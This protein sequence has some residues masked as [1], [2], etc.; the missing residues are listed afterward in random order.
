MEIAALVEN[1]GI[2]P[3]S[4]AV[5]TAHR[6]YKL[7][8]QSGFTRGRRVNQVR[9]DM[10]LLTPKPCCGHVPQRLQ[11]LCVQGLH[12]LDMLY[13][14]TQLGPGVCAYLTFSSASGRCYLPVHLLPPRAQTLHAD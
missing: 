8:L 1:F 5:G 4:E 11:Y 13:T 9:L 10:E 6:L 2:S 14:N 12:Y 7:A 3:P